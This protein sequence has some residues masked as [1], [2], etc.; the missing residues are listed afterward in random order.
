MD[1]PTIMTGVIFALMIMITFGLQILNVYVPTE[2]F[3]WLRNSIRL[4][5]KAPVEMLV[6]AVLFWAPVLML[7][8]W[9]SAFFY[10]IM[11]F[12]AVYYAVVATGATMILKNALIHYLV[13]ARANGTLIADEGKKPK[14]AA[15]DEKEDSEE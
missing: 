14:T 4:A 10:G 15:A 8:W 2:G 3:Q 7:Q 12:I 13:E 1:V 11:I 5:F 9:H 6:S